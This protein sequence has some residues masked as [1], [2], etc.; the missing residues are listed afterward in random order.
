MN[1]TLTR[2]RKI[3]RHRLT[4]PQEDY[5]FR[6]PADDLDAMD[7]ATDRLGVSIAEGMRQAVKLFLAVGMNM[8]HVHDSNGHTADAAD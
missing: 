6:L 4:G 2:R 3:K 1:T 8:H 5:C 7:T